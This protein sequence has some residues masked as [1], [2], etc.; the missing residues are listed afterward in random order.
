MRKF[1]ILSLWLSMMQNPYSW[2]VLSFSSLIFYR[3]ALQVKARR[4]FQSWG[5]VLE[6]GDT[7]FSS[8]D[9]C[10]LASDWALK[11][12]FISAKLHLFKSVILDF[13]SDVISY[14]KS[15]AVLHGIST[16]L[17]RWETRTSHLSPVLEEI[18]SEDVLGGVLVIQH[19]GEKR[20]D[21]FSRSAEF[22]QLAY[23]KKNQ[24]N[25]AAR[26]R[27]KKNKS[28]ILKHRHTHRR[29]KI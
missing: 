23:K 7:C 28:N 27:T 22:H 8:F 12:S 16:K 3:I 2:R 11:Y 13:S 1:P 5:N 9:I 15:H 25:A 20:G 18:L 21:L 24:K 17:R 10:F 29:N 6:C 26:N 14:N 19:L 4:G